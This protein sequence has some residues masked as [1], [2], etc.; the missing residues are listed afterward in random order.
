ML[1]VGPHVSAP[2]RSVHVL[3]SALLLTSLSLKR[4]PH[5]SGWHPSMAEP[6]RCL[7]RV[8]C[9]CSCYRIIEHQCVQ[10]HAS[11][12]MDSGK[13]TRVPCCLVYFVLFLNHLSLFSVLQTVPTEGWT[14]SPTP[15]YLH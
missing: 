11:H 14:Q 8:L 3:G 10:D 12:R 9:V 7:Q 2:G 5:A 13:A 15:P 1:A 6:A 4:G